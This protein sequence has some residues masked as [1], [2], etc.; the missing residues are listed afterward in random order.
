MSRRYRLLEAATATAGLD[1]AV[2]VDVDGFM[3]APGLLDVVVSQN[4]PPHN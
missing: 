1:A 4:A 3:V 2:V